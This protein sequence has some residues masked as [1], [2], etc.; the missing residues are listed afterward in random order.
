MSEGAPLE[1]RPGISSSGRW[2]T[3]YRSS[4]HSKGHSG[5]DKCLFALT[6]PARRVYALRK[7]DNAAPSTLKAE[8]M[9]EFKTDDE[10]SQAMPRW[11]GAPS[12]PLAHQLNGQCVELVCELAN[13]LSAQELPPF[14][15]ENRDL[16]RLLEPEA[17]KRVADFPFVIVKLR[18]DDAESWQQA[19]DGHLMTP[20]DVAN[21]APYSGFPPKLLEDLALETLLF[22]RQAAREDV[23][24][25][26][27]MFA[28]SSPLVRLIASLT[29]S[30]VRAIALGNASQLR[31]RWDDDPEFWCDLLVAS[32][33]GD[34]RAIEA[35]RR[36][37]KLLFCGETVPK[38]PR[39]AQVID[40]K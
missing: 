17:R 28:M 38:A 34:Q 35:I 9:D 3:V 19:S 40:G 7:T 31:V 25:A 30:Q 15:L 1:R 29:V 11:T 8:R 23:N 2:S 16:W 36:Q 4:L 13:N 22:A 20:S 5:F 37:G 10:P 33:A 24:V 6:S 21:T 12:I 32:R 18:F 14:I 39:P 27:A 26:K